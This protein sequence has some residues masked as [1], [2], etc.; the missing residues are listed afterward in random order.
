MPIKLEF[1]TSVGF[2]HNE[3][4]RKQ[5]DSYALCDFPVIASE[6]LKQNICD[7]MTFPLHAQVSSS[8]G[9]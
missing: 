4:F 9:F 1:S 3:Y 8:P 2:I 5:R 6:I 7:F